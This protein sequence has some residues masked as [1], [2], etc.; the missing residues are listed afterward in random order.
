MVLTDHGVGGFASI[1]GL[2]FTLLLTSAPS[3]L[4]GF[5]L[6]YILFSPGVC[7]KYKLMESSLASS[8][9][10]Y[11][12]KLPDIQASLDCVR[13]LKQKLEANESFT[14]FYNISDQVNVQARVE[15]QN[16]VCLWLGVSSTTM[17]LTTIR[18]QEC[19]WL[20]GIVVFSSDGPAR[21]DAVL[22]DSCSPFC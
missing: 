15:P 17:M 12:T 18:K 1:L 11:K 21:P 7:S 14:T 10:N 19:F 4:I 2:T 6:S 9:A 8:R 20:S 22:Q 5:T 16:K 13:M 3:S